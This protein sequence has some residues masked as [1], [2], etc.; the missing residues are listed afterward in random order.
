MAAHVS[1]SLKS[2]EQAKFVRKVVQVTSR[3]PDAELRGL[4]AIH[5]L[6]EGWT[7]AEPLAKAEL[8]GALAQ[9]ELLAEGGGAL[10]AADVA[11]VLGIS[12]QA[13]DKRRKTR[14]LLA[15]ELPKR[16]LLYPAWQ[17][18]HAGAVLSGIPQILDA[19]RE[20][21]AWAQ[22]RFFV[23]GNDGLAG[24]RPVDRLRAG[25]VA[26]VLHAAATF[27]EHGAA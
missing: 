20:D 25:D 12:R 23:S 1:L 5:A 7:T 9:R 2:P 22:L 19:L 11:K 8:R 4:S 15:V 21:D 6:I 10:S 13:V 3:V 16:G 27:G 17:F 14:Q 18:S 24:A 26:S